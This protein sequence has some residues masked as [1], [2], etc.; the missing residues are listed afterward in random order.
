MS[1]TPSSCATSSCKALNIFLVT[2]FCPPHRPV[3]EL[4]L[5]GEDAAPEEF[6]ELDERSVA[7][8]GAKG[9]KEENKGDDL[10]G[11][12]AEVVEI[13]GLEFAV[14]ERNMEAVPVIGEAEKESL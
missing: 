14:K 6:Y 11:V 2:F 13:D 4:E 12:E 8:T 7:A 3:Q 10:S 1:R 9:E 5:L